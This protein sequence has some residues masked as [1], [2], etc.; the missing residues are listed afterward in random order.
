M[1]KSSTTNHSLQNQQHLLLPPEKLDNEP[2]KTKIFSCNYQYVKE[3]YATT[4]A[5]QLAVMLGIIL[6]YSAYLFPQWQV[7]KSTH[8]SITAEMEAVIS[9]TSICF[10]PL[11]ALLDVI[12]IDK[13][14]RRGTLRI[15]FFFLTVGW[16]LTG[17]APNVQVFMA[18]RALNSIFVGMVAS[19]SLYVSEIS[20][21]E[22]RATFLSIISP[23]I[24][25]GTALTYVL[26]VIFHWKWT[27]F[28]VAAYS[29]ITF[30]AMFTIPETAYWYVMKGRRNE[31]ADTLK[32]FAG[33]AAGDKASNA[34]VDEHLKAI[35][36]ADRE[37]SSIAAK[38]RTFRQPA[39]ISRFVLLVMLTN[40]L[41]WTGNLAIPNYAVDFFGSLKSGYNGDVVA[42]VFGFS[43][44][45]CDLV[46]IAVVNK[47]NRKSLIAVTGIGMTIFMALTIALQLIAAGSVEESSIYR[48]LS[49]VSVLTYTAIS[50]LGFNELLWVIIPELFPTIIRG[51][52]YATLCFIYFSSMLIT[53][54]AYPLIMAH[55]GFVFLGTVFAICSVGVVLITVFFVPETRNIPLH[56][57]GTI[58]RSTETE[59]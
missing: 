33:T 47:F 45:I 37:E 10:R 35:E 15:I 24:T 13:F 39:M 30:G 51:T 29:L 59:F 19:A 7:D 9:T 4:I 17:L 46:L 3:A 56:K 57:A 49:V 55:F 40:L 53:F 31:A 25:F 38:W 2:S 22:C 16:L 11:G 36:D 28:I 48:K 6:G 12:A 42:I 18:G 27:A 23:L 50:H 41:Q 32:W 1:N 43:C 14:G 8:F 44:F 58:E 5:L 26:M 34:I 20:S 21:D 52:A 54:Y